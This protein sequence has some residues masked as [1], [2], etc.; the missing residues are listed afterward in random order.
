MNYSGGTPLTRMHSTENSLKYSRHSTEAQGVTRSGEFRI[1]VI[2]VGRAGNNT[3]T[4][5]METNPTSMKC[6]AINTDSTHLQSSQAHRKILIGQRLVKGRGV[7]RDPKL[8]KAAAV[9]SRTILEDQ[10]SGNDVV[11]ITA[12]LGG[13]TGAGAAPLICEIARSKGAVTIGVITMP[14]RKERGRDKYASASLAEMRKQCDTTVVIDNDKLMQLA[15]RLPNKEAFRIADQILANMIKGII[16]TISTPSLINL[17][18]DDFKAVISRG[19]MATVGLG[20]SSAPNRAEEALRNA[21]RTPLMDIDY[22]DATGALISVTGDNRMTV[23]EVNRIGEI[24]T[25]TMHANAQVICGA[26]V[27]PD[28]DGKLKVTLVMTGVDSP[29]Q[30]NGLARIGSQL[31]NLDPY[32]DSEKPLGIELN[33]YQMDLETK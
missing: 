5:L 32:S 30:V 23:Q 13:G 18:P 25:E 27:N 7:H 15:P 2:G 31:F 10:L 24:V 6:I 17:N 9:E 19:G 8:G 26:R 1:A 29:Q 21:L 4:K 20:E 28:L 22:A 12:G 33:L 3:V 11:F 14:F 16:E